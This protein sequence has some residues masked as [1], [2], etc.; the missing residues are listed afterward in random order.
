MSNV[1]L[2][3]PAA[4]RN[5]KCKVFFIIYLLAIHLTALPTGRQ[6]SG[7]L[8]VHL[9]NHQKISFLWENPFSSGLPEKLKNYSWATKVLDISFAMW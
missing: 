6:V 2:K 4:A 8:A 3:L 5:L 9:I 1:I 7:R